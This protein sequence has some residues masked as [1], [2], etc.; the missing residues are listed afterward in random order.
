MGESGPGGGRRVGVLRVLGERGNKI[1]EE[2]FVRGTWGFI[3]DVWGCVVV[4][5]R[6]QRLLFGFVDCGMLGACDY[7]CTLCVCVLK[8]TDRARQ[9]QRDDLIIPPWWSNAWNL[10]KVYVLLKINEGQLNFYLRDKSSDNLYV[11]YFQQNPW[12]YRNYKRILLSNIACVAKAWYKTVFLCAKELQ[13]LLTTHQ[14]VT[15]LHWVICFVITVNMD[16]TVF[17]HIYRSTAVN[18]H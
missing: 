4:G 1:Q 2:G 16:S 9:K 12:K 11:Y 8:R 14:W 18:T 3:N 6:V 7:Y 10:S 17:P 13:K 15:Q 5:W